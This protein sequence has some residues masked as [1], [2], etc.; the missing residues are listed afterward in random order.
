MDSPHKSRVALV[1]LKT[2][3]D[4]EFLLLGDLRQ[5]LEE[6]ITAQTSQ[7]LLVILDRLLRN[8]PRQF[9]LVCEDG[10]MSEVLQECPNYHGQIQLLKGANRDSISSLEEM[11]HRIQHDL[12]LATIAK[13]VSLGLRDWMNRIVALRRNENRLLQNAFTLDIGGEA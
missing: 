5:L 1:A 11:R 10:Y 13:E 8:L 3:H 9:D 6:P 7:T 12:P 4:L 2:Y